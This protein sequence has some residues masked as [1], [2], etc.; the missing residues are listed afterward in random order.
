MVIHQIYRQ[1]YHF[2]VALLLFIIRLENKMK[3]T[4]KI[5]YSLRCIPPMVVHD[6][7]IGDQSFLIRKRQQNGVK[8]I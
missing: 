4:Q 8:L 1:T 2:Q 5:N 6:K 3:S 7:T